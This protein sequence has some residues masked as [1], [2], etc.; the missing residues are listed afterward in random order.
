MAEKEGDERW[1]RVKIQVILFFSIFLFLYN[2]PL[3]KFT[4]NRYSKKFHNY[5]CVYG[6]KIRQDNRIYVR[7][8]RGAKEL[9][10]K[11]FRGCRLCKPLPDSKE[12]R[13]SKPEKS[14]PD[15]VKQPEE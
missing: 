8:T 4:A 7:T 3:K 10:K 15:E 9:E 11:G 6:V 1:K 5:D 2:C 12:Y 13:N 14:P